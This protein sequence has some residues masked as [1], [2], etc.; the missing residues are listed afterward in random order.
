MSRVAARGSYGVEATQLT[1]MAC[2]WAKAVA[3]VDLAAG[4]EVT[5][6]QTP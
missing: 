2:R 6:A 3:D 5:R 1:A 4:E